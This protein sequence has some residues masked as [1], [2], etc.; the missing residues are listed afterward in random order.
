MYD[1]NYGIVLFNDADFFAAHDF[2]EDIW[3]ECERSEKLFFQGMVQISVGCYHLICG[4]ISG[5]K[6]QLQKGILKLKKYPDGFYHIHLKMLVQ[7]LSELY[8]DADELSGSAEILLKKI[9]KIE[10]IN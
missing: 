10:L 2:F 9:P 1:I 7:K 6:S 3:F 8:T 5:A 4:N